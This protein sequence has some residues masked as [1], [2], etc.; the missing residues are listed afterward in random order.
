[1]KSVHVDEV[2]QA[3]VKDL[4]KAIRYLTM[5]ADQGHAEAATAVRRVEAAR[6][7]EAGAEIPTKTTK[8]TKKKKKKQQQQ[9][10]ATQDVRTDL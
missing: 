2:G 9:R 8:E 6:E 5:A 3:G 10:G 1:M 4:N 7:S